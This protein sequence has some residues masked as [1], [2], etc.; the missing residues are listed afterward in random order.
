LSEVRA[1]RFE[2]LGFA[3]NSAPDH[4]DQFH[5]E[6]ELLARLLKM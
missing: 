4:I 3:G 5:S 6:P 2:M 1:G